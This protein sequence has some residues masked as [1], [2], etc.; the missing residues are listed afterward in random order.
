MFLLL[1]Y[2]FALIFTV[3]MVG[4]LFGLLNDMFY[5]QMPW[6]FADLASGGVIAII[7]GIGYYFNLIS[8]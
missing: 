1:K 5:L 6:I 4:A 7:R 8:H 2:A 3:Y